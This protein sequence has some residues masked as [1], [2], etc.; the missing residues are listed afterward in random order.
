MDYSN[1]KMVQQNNSISENVVCL[2]TSKPTP[3]NVV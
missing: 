2:M 3:L 1:N